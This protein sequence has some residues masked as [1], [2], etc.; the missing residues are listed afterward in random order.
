MY[1]HDINLSV[2][3]YTIVTSKVVIHSRTAPNLNVEEQ[4]QHK[5]KPTALRYSQYFPVSANFESAFFLD[6]KCQLTKQAKAEKSI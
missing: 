6:V 2:S 1:H 4:A 5:E 3:Y